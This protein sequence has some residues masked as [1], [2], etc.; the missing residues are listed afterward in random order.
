MEPSF[1]YKIVVSCS[2]M[3]LATFM[4]VKPW[5]YSLLFAENNVVSPTQQIV[6][7]NSVTL[8]G[9]TN[10][11]NLVNTVDENAMDNSVILNSMVN[12]TFR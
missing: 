6:L 10:Q 7:R 5:P 9:L 4:I 3:A 12:L 1:C 2:V 11:N 8:N